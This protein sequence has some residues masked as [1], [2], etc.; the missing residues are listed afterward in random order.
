MSNDDSNN[1]NNKATWLEADSPTNPFGVR[2]LSLMA[3]LQ[4][5]SFTKDQEVQVGNDGERWGQPRSY[6]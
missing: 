1:G 4:M 5:Q 2:L 6:F 3:N